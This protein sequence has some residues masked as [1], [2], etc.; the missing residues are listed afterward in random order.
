[1][2]SMV[3]T[4]WIVVFLRIASACYTQLRFQCDCVQV[5][6]FFHV[7]M[8]FEYTDLSLYPSSKVYWNPLLFSATV[9]MR[10]SSDL[11][12]LY[13]IGELD[14]WELLGKQLAESNTVLTAMH[15]TIKHR[16]RDVSSQVC[17]RL[18]F[19]YFLFW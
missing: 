4:W 19:L 14:D 11:R 12:C 15:K 1:M 3:V 2:A 16:L 10:V 18:F 6:H 7:Q 5:Q 17:L 8:R 9:N 13:A